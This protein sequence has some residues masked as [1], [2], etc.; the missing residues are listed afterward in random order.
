M[1]FTLTSLTDL[2]AGQQV[3]T[4]PSLSIT[5][6]MKIIAGGA[7]ASIQQQGGATGGDWLVAV[8]PL[9]S[10]HLHSESAAGSPGATLRIMLSSDPVVIPFTD[11]GYYPI[12]VD[13]ESFMSN[14][15]LPSVTARFDLINAD[16]ANI[17]TVYGHIKI[18]ADS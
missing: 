1:A 14:L 7:T 16:A 10:W 2:P 15:L 12:P 3:V 5:Y 13:S 6:V 11:F 9:V 8:R 4:H 17:V 18:Q